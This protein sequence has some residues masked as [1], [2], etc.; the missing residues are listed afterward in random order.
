[1]RGGERIAVVIPARDE[2]AG[3]AAS[4]EAALASDSVALEV[5]VL[6]DHSTDRTAEIVQ[7]I[8]QRDPRVRAPGIT[9]DGLAKAVLVA[10]GNGRVL[11]APVH[12]GRRRG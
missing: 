1:M 5:V 7:E 6:D 8:A 10:L 12:G 2:E 3:I 11:E 9:R 4:V